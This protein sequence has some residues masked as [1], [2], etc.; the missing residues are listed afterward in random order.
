MFK[1]SIDKLR[2]CEISLRPDRPDLGVL[3]KRQKAFFQILLEN[4]A[5]LL[6]ARKF[7]HHC[8]ATLQ[9]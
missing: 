8:L 7:R 9:L 5:D 3:W 4:N 1:I 6:S 2:P